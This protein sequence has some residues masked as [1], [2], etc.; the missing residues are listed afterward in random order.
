M[1]SELLQYGIFCQ[2]TADALTRKRNLHFLPVRGILYADHSALAKLFMTDPVADGKIRRSP[3]RFFWHKICVNLAEQA[4][5][6]FAF[7]LKPFA[8][9]SGHAA[10]GNAALA[11]PAA[12]D[13]PSFVVV[14]V[15]L[16]SRF[17]I[18]AAVKRVLPISTVAVEITSPEPTIAIT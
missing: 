14:T 2:Q 5:G 7:F 9:G 1:Q 16:I 18:T 8:E 15:T 11:A 13:D 12:D 17:S 10:V 6:L 4:A 3:R